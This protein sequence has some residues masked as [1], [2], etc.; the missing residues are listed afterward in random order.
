MRVNVDDTPTTHQSSMTHA[1][2]IAGIK[3]A[4]TAAPARGLCVDFNMPSSADVATN[5]GGQVLSLAGGFTRPA[6]TSID[7]Q[8]QTAW[9][10]AGATVADISEELLVQ[11]WALASLGGTSTQTIA[12]AVALDARGP[13]LSGSTTSVTIARTIDFV[14]GTGELRQV[15]SDAT[16]SWGVRAMIGGLGL[17][18]ICTELEVHIRPVST[19]WM[20]VDSLRCETA[21]DVFSHLSSA[22]AD[23]YAFARINPAGVGAGLGRGIVLSAQQA[24]VAELPETRQATALEYVRPTRTP[25]ATRLPSNLVRSTAARKIQNVTHRTAPAARRDELVPMAAFFHA[26]AE[27][28][29][30]SKKLAATFTYEFTVPLDQQVLIPEFLDRLIHANVVGDC[31]TLHR[32]P[33][34]TT[35]PLGVSVDGWTFS[36]E[37]SP[38][39]AGLG[40]LLDTW[41]EQLAACGGQVALAYDAR[42]RADIV[43]SMY[44][45]LDR[46]HEL[47]TTTDPA[48]R[49][50]SNLSRRLGL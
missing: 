19:G 17:T 35:G 27:A 32:T 39:A 20:L 12:G 4:V 31:A 8:S 2:T 49:F 28:R 44:P 6:V 26:D 34:R 16:D 46:W 21:D 42:M 33:T 38:D 10:A 43:R 3:A 37:L 50:H 23:T 48:H 24:R 30:A 41:D 18:G 7:W 22:S 9:V 1:R 15:G 36:I 5:F 45:E 13:H 47:R 11:G 40:R 14:D 25:S 29:E